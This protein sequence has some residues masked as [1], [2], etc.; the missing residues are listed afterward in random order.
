[1]KKLTGFAFLLLCFAILPGKKLFSQ[2]ISLHKLFDNYYKE[3]MQL[4]PFEATQNG[5]STQNDK[6]YADF[7]D[8][9]RAKL[10]EFFTRF[11]KEIRKL[12]KSKLNEDDRISYNIF[13]KEME[14]TLE[15]L[16]AG[17][18]S[19]RVLYP[20][21]QYMPFNQFGGTPIWLGQLGSGTGQQPFKS[22]TD[23]DKWITRASSFPAWMDSAIIYFRKGIHANI[24]LPRALVEKMI[25]Q[26]E[27]MVVSDP[28]KS[29]FYGPIN[30]M[31][32][33]F[34]EKNKSK[35]TAEFVKLINEKLMP[36]YD[37]MGKFL[38]N[39]YLGKARVTSG[40]NALSSGRK[41]YTYLIHFWTTT[42][43][44]P[45]EIYQTG[46]N[47]VKRIR[48]IM[49]SVKNSVGFKGDLHTFFAY[50]KTD[51]G[52]MPYKTP[53]EVLN[54]YRAIQLRIDPNLKKM[55]NHVPK[56]KF[57][58][59]Q[60]E[61]Y[62]AASASASYSPGSAE[63]NRPGVFYVPILDATKFNV[64]T[65]MEGLFLHEAIPGHHYQMSLQMENENLPKF[66]RYTFY[67]AY[68]EGWGLY[69]ESLGKELGVYTDPYQYLGALVKEIHRSIRLVVDVGMHHMGWTREEAIK[70]MSENMPLSEKGVIAE[71]ERYMGMPG[72]ALSYKI[73]SLKIRELRSKYEKMLGS[74]FDL[75]TF[76]DAFLQGGAMQLDILEKKMDDWAK[77]LKK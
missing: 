48:A 67:G 29:L 54:A 7:T 38:K 50:M 42:N 31:P 76:H 23:Y 57:E 32:S 34:S 22:T 24:V 47:E 61:A 46:L 59:R 52:F 4:I 71:I 62:R 70:Y 14:V 19:N 26:M 74:K 2:N 10:K 25:P 66:R 58:I 39:E 49:D 6:L 40:I 64:T 18:F 37:K 36:A 69:C 20:E 63:G 73:G 17:Y 30:L 33:S 5:D 12:N 55:F 41:D 72:Q 56:T 44:S 8:S 35:L 60:V 43:K 3:R 45:E 53:E 21:H 68:V 1:M 15:G 11:Q 77:T 9:Y 51:P 27:A 28:T 16:E 13:T 65:G 75:A